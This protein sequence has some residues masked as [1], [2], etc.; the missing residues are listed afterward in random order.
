[1]ADRA[2]D[3]S[4]SQ[5][6][7]APPG[8]RDS[9]R[10]LIVV[11]R[12]R[13]RSNNRSSC[14]GGRRGSAE[15]PSRTFRTT[16]SGVPARPA[17]PSAALVR[18]RR[19]AERGFGPCRLSVRIYGERANGKGR[20]CVWLAQPTRVTAR[21]RRGGIRSAGHRRRLD[22]HAIVRTGLQT[23]RWRRGWAD[24]GSCGLGRWRR[25]PGRCWRRAVPLPP[26][27]VPPPV[28]GDRNVWWISRIVWSRTS[29]A[30]TAPS[31]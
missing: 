20:P 28:A 19:G 9:P 7:Y 15:T 16:I 21:V 17:R 2:R 12:V 8:L 4:R 26:L 29:Q 27:R 24:A 10:P 1:M 31:R 14:R 3:A 30:S 13:G 23:R 25:L 18:M 22:R 5:R 11:W 6:S